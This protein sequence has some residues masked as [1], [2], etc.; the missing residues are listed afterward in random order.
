MKRVIK[1]V[2]KHDNLVV[3]FI[4]LLSIVGISLNVK[5]IA[6]DELWNFQNIYKLY[7]GFEIYKDANIITTPLFFYVGNLLFKLMGANFFTFS[8]YNIIID[9]ILFLSTYILCKKLKI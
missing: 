1:W 6:S 4:I 8:V 9:I 2:R 3:C 5:I 7:N